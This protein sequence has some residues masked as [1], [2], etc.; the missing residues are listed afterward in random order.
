M[1]DVVW[2]LSS[3][4]MTR[5]L[6]ETCVSKTQGWLC[7]SPRHG[8]GS[9]LPSAACHGFLSHGLPLPGADWEGTS[10]KAGQQDMR[11]AG[12]LHTHQAGCLHRDLAAES[13]PP[14]PG[15]TLQQSPVPGSFPRCHDRRNPLS[16]VSKC[17]A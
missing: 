12:C 14:K 11:W 16:R 15:R 2:V 3:K 9:C 6:R 8:V 1:R 7:R 17:S 13:C 10:C 4:E 5:K